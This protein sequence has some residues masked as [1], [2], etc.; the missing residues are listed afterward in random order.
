[1]AVGVSV[2][3]CVTVGV[4]VAV[5]VAVGVFVGVGVLVGV[6]VSV[7][8]GCLFMQRLLTSAPDRARSNSLTSSITPSAKYGKSG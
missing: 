7:D 3:V 8:S 4:G 1:V 6:G 5:R 2:G